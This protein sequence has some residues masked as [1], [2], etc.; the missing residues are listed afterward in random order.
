MADEEIV[1]KHTKAAYEALKTRE[2]NWKH[3][4]KEILLEI[5]II[6]FAVSV[7]IWFHNRSERLKDRAEEKKFLA[8]LKKDLQEDKNEMINAGSKHLNHFA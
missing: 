1:M 3:K 7:S 6:V 4:L 5:I 8:S 2:T